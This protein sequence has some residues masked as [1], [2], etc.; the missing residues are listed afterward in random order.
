MSRFEILLRIGLALSDKMTMKTTSLIAVLT[1]LTLM[2]F[3]AAAKGPISKARSGPTSKSSSLQGAHSGSSGGSLSTGSGE[4]SEE[5]VQDA[6]KKTQEL[7][8]NPELRK[9]NAERDPKAKHADDMVNAMTG[10]NEALNNEIY[11][12]A[13]KVFA[14]IAAQA[15]GDPKA[16]EELLL[17]FQRDPAGFAGT[18][19]PEER[20]RLKEIA[21]QMS[22]PP[23]SPPK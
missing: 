2:G 12:L 21:G 14:S 11:A 7:M 20:A 4:A 9:Q 19:S 23:T 13:S 15:K 5:D 6:L 8:E 1:A 10:G 22:A 17:K 18:W 3:Q 16:M